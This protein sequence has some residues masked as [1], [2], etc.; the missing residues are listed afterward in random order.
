MNTQHIVLIGFKHVGKSVLG[1]QLA[2]RR[3]TLCIDLDRAI[4]RSYVTPDTVTP[5]T[6]RQIVQTHGE[7]FFRQRETQILEQ[8]LQ[9]RR[10]CIISVGGGTPLAEQ[11]QL[12]LKTQKIVYITA[13]REMVFNRIMRKGKPPFFP[14]DEDPWIAFNRLWEER[15]KI[16]RSL[17]T[18]TVE[19][20]G[21]LAETI[22][23]ILQKL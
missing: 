5:L 15:E 7:A 11:N 23:Q 2:R 6:C 22:D 17:A 12:L 19:N 1:Q 13:P 4:E 21:K 10:P 20:H 9:L 18:I 14:A 8:V 16:Y 3:H